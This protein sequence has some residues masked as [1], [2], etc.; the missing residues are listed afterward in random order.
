[1]RLWRSGYVFIMAVGLC[2]GSGAAAAGQ[3]RASFMTIDL[4]AP[5]PTDRLVTQL[6]AKRV[7]FVGETHDR[8]DNH[9]RADAIITV[10]RQSFLDHL[11]SDGQTADSY[12]LAAF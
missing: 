10:L 5:L 11:R 4:D 7:V 6:A 12:S 9:L 1:M 2:C 3:D 8:Y